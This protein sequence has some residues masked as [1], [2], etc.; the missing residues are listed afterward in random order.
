MTIAEEM[1]SE[2]SVVVVCRTPGFFMS[3]RRGFI[4]E[5]VYRGGATWSWGHMEEGVQDYAILCCMTGMHNYFNPMQLPCDCTIENG[6]LP[7]QNSVTQTK[8][9]NGMI[10]FLRFINNPLYW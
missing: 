1:G 8:Y 4:E 10:L 5:G 7:L 3:D 9:K 2:F 6:S